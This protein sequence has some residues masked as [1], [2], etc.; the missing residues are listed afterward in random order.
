[1][2][3]LAIQ[4]PKEGEYA[5]YYENYINKAGDKIFKILESQV[6]DVR[7]LMSEVPFEKENYSYAPGKW[8]LKEVLG[9]IN[10]SERIMGYRA[11]CI[12]RGEKNKL[13]GFD[14][15]AYVG[16]T[17]YSKRSL[18]D[19]AH[20]FGV[21]RDSNII[22][23]NSFIEKDLNRKGIANENEISVRAL[24]YVIAGHVNHHLDIIRERYWA[25]I[26]VE[27]I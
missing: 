22:L 14:E 18:N 12:A 6:L 20:E 27:R 7:A 1:M 24:I 9:H 16:N 19:L 8:T 17:D 4:R 26:A 25:K 15:N 5:K 21:I 11:L 2:E 13:P 10:D 23:F 3:T